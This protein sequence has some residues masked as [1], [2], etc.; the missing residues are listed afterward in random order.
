MY[1]VGIMVLIFL[2]VF[3]TDIHA[4]MVF[5]ATAYTRRHHH[6]KTW[7]RARKHYKSNWNL[8]QR[9][10]WIPV[11]KECYEKKYRALAIMLYV[12]LFGSLITATMFFIDHFLIS[13]Y[14][15]WHYCFIVITIIFE[16]RYVYSD[17][18]GKGKI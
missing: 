13:N 18:L 3:V 10:L 15:F 1:I 9:L 6:G 17:L 11:F 12:H 16:I 5:V 4:R 8:F 7:K 2:P 14:T